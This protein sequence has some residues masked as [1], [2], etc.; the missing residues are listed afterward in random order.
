MK[1]AGAFDDGDGIITDAE[2][3]AYKRSQGET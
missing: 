1:Q 3:S 2:W